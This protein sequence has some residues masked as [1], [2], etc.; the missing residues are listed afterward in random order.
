L[1]SIVGGTAARNADQNSAIIAHLP[2]MLIVL[3][4]AMVCVLFVMT[5]SVVLPIKALM[6]NALSVIAALGLLVVIFQD[7]WFEGPLGFHGLGGLENSQPVLQGAIAFGLAT[8]YGVFLI[9][10][11]REEHYGGATNR[12][13]IVRGVSRTGP[14]ITAAALLFCV[15]IGALVTSPLIQIKQLAVGTVLAVAIDATVVRTFLA[16][17]TMSLLGRWNWYSP[18]ALRRFS[19]PAVTSTAHDGP[20][21]APSVTTNS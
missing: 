10:R 9:A 15:A 14:V 13:A 2:R 20:Q 4:V 5:G 16:P 19:A 3:G 12:D 17:A 21:A 11:I 8:D 6:M 7:G 18:R 1:R